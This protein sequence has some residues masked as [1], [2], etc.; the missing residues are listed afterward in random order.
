MGKCLVTT[1]VKSIA[2][3][4]KGLRFTKMISTDTVYPN[5]CKRLTSTCSPNNRTMNVMMG[6]ITPSNEHVVEDVIKK[7]RIP[8]LQDGCWISIN[9]LKAYVFFGKRYLPESRAK[10][11]QIIKPLHVVVNTCKG[12]ILFNF[13][14]PRKHFLPLTVS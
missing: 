12:F 8:P 13:P 6:S 2:R 14:K 3:I 4:N 1:T 5:K 7:S 10:I 9:W 11:A